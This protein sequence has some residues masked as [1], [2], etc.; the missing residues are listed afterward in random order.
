MYVSKKVCVIGLG[1]VGVPLLYALAKAGHKVI[2]YDKDEFRVDQLA[3]GHDPTGFVPEND[4]TLQKTFVTCEG[5]PVGMDFYIVCV[6][7]PLNINGIPDYEAV[8]DVAEQI[9]KVASPQSVAILES[10]VAPGTTEGIF[11][12]RIKN[13]SVGRI[14]N[15]RVAFSPERMNPG[16]DSF[17]QWFEQ[18]KVVGSSDP[19]S[20]HYAAAL[21]RSV[22][23]ERVQTYESA[24]I[25]EYAKCFENMQ[26]YINIALMNELVLVAKHKGLD[27]YSIIDAAST[28]FNWLGFTPGMVGGHCI[29]VD[30]FFLD[31]W[32][33]KNSPSY[34]EYT[35]TQHAAAVH[36]KY[37]DHVINE[38]IVHIN[39]RRRLVGGDTVNVLLYGRSYKPDVEDS[40]NAATTQ[41]YSHLT[42]LFRTSEVSVCVYDPLMDTELF[43][44][45]I[46]ETFDICVGIVSHTNTRSVSI[47]E[48]IKFTNEAVFIEVGHGFTRRQKAGFKTI[49]K[50]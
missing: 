22:F 3:N 14:E 33:Y 9:G 39:N 12:E 19:T 7:T 17:E 26:R 46:T 38:L 42:D 44:N 45:T 41:I 1:Y 8:L 49:V 6:P 31:D 27:P 50:I 35:F 20:R 30:P 23:H 11:A 18:I 21:Y 28:K 40:R 24:A 29:P 48:T 47:K 25:P 16:N 43:M 2:G 36:D 4:L 15:P 13:A 10:T 32:V 37:A 5:V 34:V